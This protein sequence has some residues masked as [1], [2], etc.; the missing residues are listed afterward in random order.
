[1]IEDVYIGDGVYVSF[2]GYHLVLDLRAQ[3]S[4][5]RIA[6]EPECWKKLREYVNEIAKI[7]GEGHA[8][9]KANQMATIP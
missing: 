7:A 9:H 4:G 5:D 8:W 6:L 2:D 1:M 3:P